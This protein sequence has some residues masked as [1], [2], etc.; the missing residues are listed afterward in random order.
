MHVII[1]VLL[2]HYKVQWVH[3]FRFCPPVRDDGEEESFPRG[4]QQSLTPLEKRVIQQKAKEDVLFSEVRVLL[5]AARF[6]VFEQVSS[7]MG[8]EAL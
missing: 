2:V 5:N 3:V 1:V 7:A 8:D 6:F 4:G